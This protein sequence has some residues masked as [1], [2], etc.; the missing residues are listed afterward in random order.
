[1]QTNKSIWSDLHK[2]LFANY[3]S[4]K[5]NGLMNEIFRVVEFHFSD[6]NIMKSDGNISITYTYSALLDDTLY[7]LP[8]QHI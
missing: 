5:K 4:F 6:R 2:L 8:W 7:T 1:M 3:Q